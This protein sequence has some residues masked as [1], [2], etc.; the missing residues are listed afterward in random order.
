MILEKVRNR[1]D[2]RI[3]K[4]ENGWIKYENPM[5][6]LLHTSPYAY[7]RVVD[8][9]NRVL[10]KRNNFVEDLVAIRVIYK[11]VNVHSNSELDNAVKSA[12]KEN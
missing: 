2:E 1:E 3:A 8:A 12:I 9:V 10:G 5:T 11:R 4:S 6:K 7:S